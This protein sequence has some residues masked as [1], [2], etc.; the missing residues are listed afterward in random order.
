[1]SGRPRIGKSARPPRKIKA[2][3][4]T[5]KDMDKARHSIEYVKEMLDCLGVMTQRDG[6]H[7]LAYLIGLAALEAANLQEKS[8]QA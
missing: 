6:W 7:L 3:K 8:R 1:M 4:P 2:A 5:A